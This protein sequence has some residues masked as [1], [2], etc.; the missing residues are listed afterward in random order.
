MNKTVEGPEW[1]IAVL[2]PARNEAELLPRCLRSIEAARRELPRGVTSD[3]VVVSDSSIDGTPEIA[4][5]MLR[6]RGVVLTSDEG[7]VGRARAVA[8]ETAIGR[9]P[10]TLERVWLANTD[11]DCEV[12]QNW[13]T[14]QLNVARRGF[15]AVAGT[16]EVDTFAEHD[17]SVA[18]LF[19]L[20]YLIHEDGTHPHVHGAN[21]GVRADA[22]VQAGGWSGLETAED[23]DLWDR[24][25]SVGSRRL[26]DASLRVLT[27]GRRVGRAPRGFADA[28]AAHN[29]IST[30]TI[31]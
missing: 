29:Q 31:G 19:R 17:E 4:A 15:A 18:E 22:Y 14:D 21:L 16:V 13:L 9:C 28:L 20:T 3:V 24:L 7:V 10:G 6:G 8:A 27:S 2:I 30:G 26:S 23:H 11:A 5:R 12:P 25:K 1:H